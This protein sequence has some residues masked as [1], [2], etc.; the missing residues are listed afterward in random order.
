MTNP[1]IK[2]DFGQIEAGSQQ[3][4]ATATQIDQL[5][6]DLHNQIQDLENIWQ[7]S[8][9]GDFQ[10]TKHKWEQ[11]AHDLQQVLASIGAAVNSAHEAYLQTEATN[12]ASWT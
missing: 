8:T 1:S 3:I 10:N 2:V 7:G 11:S 4:T 12:S 9:S 6:D 5:L